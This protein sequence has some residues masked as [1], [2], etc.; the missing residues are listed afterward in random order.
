METNN[1]SHGP[2]PG[3]APEAPGGPALVRW[4]STDPAVRD[5][6]V[7]D[8][9]YTV[10]YAGTAPLLDR[11]DA[12]FARCGVSLRHP[13][14]VECSQSVAGALALLHLLSREYDVVLLPEL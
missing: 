8:G 14:A 3:P 1:L 11:L 9:R 5:R 12:R 6:V 7:T 4:L 2:A 13:V 10:S